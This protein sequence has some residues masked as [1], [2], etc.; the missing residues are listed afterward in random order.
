ML[1]DKV[2]SNNHCTEGDVKQKHPGRSVSFNFTSRTS[3]MQRTTCLLYVMHVYKRK[4]TISSSFLKY[5]K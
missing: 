5:D 1:K 4:E 3:N 2:Y